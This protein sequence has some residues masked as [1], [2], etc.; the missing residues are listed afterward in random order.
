[1]LWYQV[2]AI[3]CNVF[4]KWEFVQFLSLHLLLSKQMFVWPYL[5]LYLQYSIT[6]RD[7]GRLNMSL[8]LGK[9]RD[10]YRILL[11]GSHKEDWK[12]DEI[13]GKNVIWFR[14]TR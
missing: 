9:Q 4:H 7:C 10:A 8:R 5:V 3:Y 13:D 12:G 6:V 11:E 14:V 1:M 2:I